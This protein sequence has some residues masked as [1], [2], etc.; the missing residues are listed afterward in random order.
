MN[1]KEAREISEKAVD[2][3]NIT[4]YVN[5]ILKDIKREAEKGRTELPYDGT[6]NGVH[7]DS[8]TEKLVFKRLKTLGYKITH[9]ASCDQRE[10]SY[11]TISW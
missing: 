6:A 2:S 8:V 4:E 7:I 5:C 9:H 11:D 10:P 3:V 1:A